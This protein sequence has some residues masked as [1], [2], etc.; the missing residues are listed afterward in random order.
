MQAASVKVNSRK[1]MNAAGAST[2]PV[3]ITLDKLRP[4]FHMRQEIA[5][6]MLGVSLSSLKS[7][8]RRLGLTRWPYTRF[9]S[10]EGSSF[11]SV[12][13]E[14]SIDAESSVASSD[15]VIAPTENVNHPAEEEEETQDEPCHSPQSDSTMI[16]GEFIL[17]PIWISWYVSLDESDA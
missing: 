7:S 10:N 5:A 6:D 1:R 2:R 11:K 13:V 8:C 17:D 3:E 14:S 15:T 12:L 16:D 9:V 4:L